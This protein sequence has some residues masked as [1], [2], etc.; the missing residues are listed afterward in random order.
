MSWLR[1]LVSSWKLKNPLVNCVISSTH[2]EI[3][4]YH[5]V[6]L[7]QSSPRGNDK[8]IFCL[9]IHCLI[10]LLFCKICEFSR[11]LLFVPI[12]IW[13][14]SQK[15]QFFVE[16][17]ASDYVYY[18]I[19]NVCR[20]HSDWNNHSENL[21]SQNFVR[22]ENKSVRF[23]RT[24]GENTSVIWLLLFDNSDQ[25]NWIHIYWI[26]GLSFRPWKLHN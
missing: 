25:G 8:L 5:A 23:L 18:Y 13:L 1:H 20:K 26:L 11:K 14:Y 9:G 6:L 16:G 15:S 19:L 22:Q 3:W 7:I 4:N 24:F 12:E 17:Y 10:G 21:K 2:R